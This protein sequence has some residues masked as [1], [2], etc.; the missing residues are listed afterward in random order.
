MVARWGWVVDAWGHGDGNEVQDAMHASFFLFLRGGNAEK[1]WNFMYSWRWCMCHK[2]IW[3]FFFYAMN[4][5]DCMNV[6]QKTKEKH[7]WYLKLVFF[8]VL[9]SFSLLTFF[10]RLVLSPC[11]CI[12]LLLVSLPFFYYYFFKNQDGWEQL[13]FFDPFLFFIIF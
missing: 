11:T 6:T 5:N 10:F 1:W 3:M 8:S 13:S 7:T 2:N 12:S 9:S 4:V